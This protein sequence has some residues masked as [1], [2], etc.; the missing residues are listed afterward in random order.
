MSKIV[1]ICYCIHFLFNDDRRKIRIFAVIVLI[2][3]AIDMAVTHVNNTLH[4]EYPNLS[5]V[6]FNAKNQGDVTLSTYRAGYQ[7]GNQFWNISSG[8]LGVNPDLT[9]Y[10]SIQDALA[11]ERPKT[12][13]W[14]IQ[15]HDYLTDFDRPLPHCRWTDWISASINVQFKWKEGVNCVYNVKQPE[16]A[17]QA[18]LS[19]DRLT[20]KLHIGE[21]GDYY[22]IHRDERGF[23]YLIVERRLSEA[24]TKHL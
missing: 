13:Y 21:L 9:P 22:I 16:G 23:G 4:S 15:P 14:I 1:V 7:M 20:E 19:L 17:R 11:G 12:R 24:E 3:I 18:P 2:V 8:Y 10:L 6:G 5:W